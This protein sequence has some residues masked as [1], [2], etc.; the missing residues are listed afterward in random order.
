[1]NTENQCTKEAA[2]MS[3]ASSAAQQTYI[4][5]GWRELEEKAATT[6]GNWVEILETYS[7]QERFLVQA[8][9]WE[10]RQTQLRDEKE[11]EEK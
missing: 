10:Q 1:M 9:N 4:I 11:T 3:V 5:M 6:D 8:I 7:S 2:T